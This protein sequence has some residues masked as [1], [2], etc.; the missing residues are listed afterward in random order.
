MWHQ[1]HVFNCL[2]NFKVY[3]SPRRIY[4]VEVMS[5]TLNLETVLTRKSFQMEHL[6][7]PDLTLENPLFLPMY[8]YVPCDIITDGT[9]VTVNGGVVSSEVRKRYLRMADRYKLCQIQG[10]LLFRCRLDTTFDM[11][12]PSTPPIRGI[13]TGEDDTCYITYEKIGS[14]KEYAKCQTC[15]HNFKREQFDKWYSA[16]G[17]CPM[18]RS[19]NFAHYKNSGVLKVEEC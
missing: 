19:V 16:R 1:N 11:S 7:F 9:K 13:T 17:I 3:G 14:T 6:A 10:C 18:R 15:K 5:Y 12:A 2:F 8:S 4:C